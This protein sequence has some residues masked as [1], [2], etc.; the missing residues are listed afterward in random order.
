MMFSELYSAYYNAVAAILK[1]AV[2]HPVTKSEIRSIVEEKAFG[3]S[4][5]TIPASLEEERWP[6]LYTDGTTPLRHAPTLPITTL[7]KR[8]LKAIASDPRV[9]LFGDGLPDFPDV[10]P[11]YRQEDVIVF[12]R[13]ADGDPYG[14]AGYIERFGL[15]LRAVREQFPLRIEMKGRRA[16]PRKIELLPDHLEYSEK[17][18]KF[19]LI[20]YTR[21][22]GR[23]T[24][25][26]ARILTCEAMEMP[27]GGFF[28]ER[29]EPVPEEQVTVVMELTDHRNALER[30]LLHFA[31]YRKEAVRLDG[32]RY[33]V[34]VTFDRDE[35]ADILIRVLSFGPMV[36]VTAPESFIDLIRQKLIRQKSCGP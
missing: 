14:D 1:A 10:K 13:F 36:R 8:W 19:R 28:R 20:G 27:E 30:V 9:R 11:L 32:D 2:D 6:F 5:L 16:S 17:D 18:D 22:Y 29:A 24:V 3:E 21:R 15:I 12:D 26:L 31:S 35:E 23:N 34:S 25:N 7:E 4:I 33:R